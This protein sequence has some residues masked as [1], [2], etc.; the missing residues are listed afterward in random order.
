MRTDMKIEQPKSLTEMV[1]ARLE[2]AIVDGEFGLG[3]AIS[4][5][6]LA[7]TFG[8]S[9]TPVRD[10]LTALQRSGLVV[11]LAKRGSFVFRPSA[12]D[13]AALCD[14][15]FLLECEGLRLSRFAA[16]EETQIAMLAAIRAMEASLTS[17]AVAYGR[18]DT[19][20]HQAFLDHCGNPYLSEAYRLASGR[21]AALR[22][23]LT[24]HV[25]ARRSHSLDEHRR[26]A[27]LFEVGDLDALFALLAEHIN[28][29]RQV[30][31]AALA[32][33]EPGPRRMALI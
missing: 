19:Q 28:R 20:F 32:T 2:Q 22:T 25:E 3:E 4:E 13:T 33:P 11:V 21:V 8:V 18:A 30:Y 24:A 14:Y 6:T 10:A 16:P 9:R 17:D 1:M 26:M 7:K 12:A 31:E 23:H 27:T 29:T 5:E 15:R